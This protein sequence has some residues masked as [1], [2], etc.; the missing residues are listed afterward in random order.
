MNESQETK[1]FYEVMRGSLEIHS[2]SSPRKQ[3]VTDFIAG[4]IVPLVCACAEG[5]HSEF[6]KRFDNLED[7]LKDAASQK[8]TLDRI[9][10]GIYHFEEFYVSEMVYDLDDK[11]EPVWD[12]GY[13]RDI[14]TTFDCF[15]GF[16]AETSRDQLIVFQ[17]DMESVLN[18]CNLNHKKQENDVTGIGYQPETN[19]IIAVNYDKDGKNPIE[20]MKY[21]ISLGSYEKNEMIP[22][23]ILKNAFQNNIELTERFQNCLEEKTISNIRLYNDGLTDHNPAIFSRKNLQGM[24]FSDLELQ[25]ALFIDSDLRYA[26][27][28]ESNLSHASFQ[29]ADLRGAS[30]M[31]CNLSHTDFTNCDLRDAV[32]RGADLSHAKLTNARLEGADLEGVTIVDA[33]IGQTLLEKMSL[34]KMKK[35]LD[36]KEEQPAPEKKQK[37][38]DMVR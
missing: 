6:Q 12:E 23:D 21:V 9:N 5:G 25:H 4:S 16:D 27:F 18:A 13:E 38:K 28:E 35:D 34:D 11:N 30:F 33:E 36:A 24:E 1:T 26:D 7:A 29:N 2:L 8:P 17:P 32:L 14:H 19:K 20:D 37:E 15:Y 31:D 22:Y 10:A 3:S